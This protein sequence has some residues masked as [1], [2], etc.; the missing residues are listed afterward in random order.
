MKRFTY[1]LMVSFSLCIMV[2]RWSI[3]LFGHYPPM[4]WR[5]KELP[6][7]SKLSMADVGSL[8]NHSHATPLRM[9]RKERHNISSGGC[10]RPKV[11]S[12]VLRWFRGS[13]RL[14]NDLSCGRW[15]FEGIGHSRTLVVKGKFVLLTIMSK[16]RSVFSL[17][18]LLSLSISILI[19]LKR[20]EFAPSRV[21]GRQWS[22]LL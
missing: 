4:K 21:V 10:W 13:F 6:N 9:M 22:F 15:N 8:L 1:D 5:K 3:G 19:S 7:C 17:I 16:L 20:S 2:S 12:K 11:V 14:L 18:A